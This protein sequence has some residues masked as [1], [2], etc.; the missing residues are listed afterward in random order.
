MSVHKPGDE[1]RAPRHFLE[2][3]V[4]LRSM[5][6]TSCESTKR[7]TCVI[8]FGSFTANWNPVTG[9]EKVKVTSE[10]SPVMRP[11]SPLSDDAM[12]RVRD[13][14]DRYIRAAIHDRW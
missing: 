1:R 14:Y 13:V 5:S 2:T 12:D 9:S 3:K 10:V 7:R 6:R 8:S 4:K 11:L